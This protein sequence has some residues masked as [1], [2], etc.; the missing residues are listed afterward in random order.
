MNKKEEKEIMKNNLFHK[1]FGFYLDTLLF[2]HFDESNNIMYYSNYN[3]IDLYKYE[4]NDKLW[5]F[6]P[7][8]VISLGFS[9]GKNR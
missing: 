2:L 6:I 1:K 5:S 4:I 7:N 3:K 8:G 9:I